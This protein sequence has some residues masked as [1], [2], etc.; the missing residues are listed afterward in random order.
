[1]GAALHLEVGPAEHFA[2]RSPA[3]WEHVLGVARYAARPMATMLDVP[4]AQV[5]VQALHPA[6][7]VCEVWRAPGRL[8][9]GE[10]G[11]LRWRASDDVLFAAQ[12][13]AED[14][15]L[16]HATQLAYERLF[17]TLDA[18][19]YPHLLRVWHHIADIN[20]EAS[21]LERYRRF[22][23]GRQNAFQAH[24]RGIEG[25]SVPAASA[26]G[27]DRHAPLAVYALALRHAPSAV[28]NPRQVS[29]YHYPA[30]HGPRSPTFSRAALATLGG[31]VL[32]VSG[33]ASIVGHRSLHADDVAEQTRETLRNISAVL[34]QA[35]EQ[36]TPAWNLDDLRYKVYLRRACDLALVNDELRQAVG[37]EVQAMF[38][39]AD[40]CR[41]DL[42]VEIEAVVL[43]QGGW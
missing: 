6:T 17:T 24:G 31:A 4:W 38:L 39:Q 2:S 5:Q 9:S 35:R 32:F 7:E 29:A 20:A 14:D 23:I 19:G 34:A 37:T 42:L 15:D 3:W 1:M 36:G 41:S 40:V 25:G 22:N 16:E 33:T 13:V 21:G 18:A 11:P 8:R 30:V 43:P 10:A 28:E 12:N 27:A 26:L